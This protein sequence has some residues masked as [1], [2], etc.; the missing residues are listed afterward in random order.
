MFVAWLLAF[1]LQRR[2][3]IL[4]KYVVEKDAAE[5][6]ETEDSTARGFRA[7]HTAIVRV[8][9]VVDLT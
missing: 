8:Q 2:R 1:Q 7:K 4:R 6:G 3:Q 5:L 9:T